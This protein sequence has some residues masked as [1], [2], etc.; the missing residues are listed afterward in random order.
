VS[1]STVEI[2]T[3]RVAIFAA[4]TLVVCV[5]PLAATA[6]WLA[7]LFALPLLALA[8]VLRLGVDIDPD[9]MTVR[10]VVGSRRLRWDEIA[11]L[12]AAPNGTLSV[13]LTRGARIRLP[14]ARAR[15]LAVIAAASGGRVDASV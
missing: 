6:W 12:R 7:V 1:G 9:G 8:A 13:V 14:V 4:L 5:I 11:G 10:G 3:S 2:R 15:H